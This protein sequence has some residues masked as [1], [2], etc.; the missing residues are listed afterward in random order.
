VE[1]TWRATKLRTKTG[2]LVVLPNSLVAGAAVSNYSEPA[3][4]TRIE[5]QVGASYLTP[6]NRTREALLASVA[7]VRRVL[8]SPAPDVLFSEFSASALTFRLRFW[9]NDF[10]WEEEIRSEVLT[11]IYYEFDRSHIEIPYP[12][13]IEHS[14]EEPRRDSPERRAEY[15]RSIAG[16]PV[17]QVLPVEAQ[18]ALALAAAE[19]L[20]ADGEVIVREGDPAGSLFI[21]LNGR[22][23]VTVGPDAT[24]VAITEAGGFFGEM[25]LLTGQPRTATVTARGDCQ[26]LE[27]T[28]A[29]FRSHVLSRPEVIDA[30][31]AVAADRQKALDGSRQAPTSA[32]AEPRSLARRMRRF[33]GLA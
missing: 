9:V 32:A 8:P 28:S 26:V 27:I 3:A 2:N 20:Y 5:V 21:V 15:A 7:R 11:A 17:F 6:P 30:L 14:R 33:F 4:P 23:G 24:E 31:A 25:S 29:D 13:Q 18:Q 19:R 16:V 1:V 12:I 22:V 10:E